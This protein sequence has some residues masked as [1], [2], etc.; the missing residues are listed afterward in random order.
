[1]NPKEYHGDA[2]RYQGGVG[3][4]YPAMLRYLLRE[5]SLWANFGHHI[6][7]HLLG[8]W[9]QYLAGPNFIVN[10]SLKGYDEYA[11]KN[12]FGYEPPR[13]AFAVV[14]PE[15]KITMQMPIYAEPS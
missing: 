13:Q 6:D 4:I 15:R 14:T 5:Q 10:G 3:G 1:M 11:M 8:H 9:H 7:Y 12:A 2:F